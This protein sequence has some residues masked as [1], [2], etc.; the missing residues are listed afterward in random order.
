MTQNELRSYWF[1]RHGCFFN[2]RFRL[3]LTRHTWGKSLNT[4][5]H[6]TNPPIGIKAALLMNELLTV[7]EFHELLAAEAVSFRQL[8]HR[9][10]MK[11]GATNIPV[12]AT[13][14]E[15]IK[16]QEVLLYAFQH[17]LNSLEPASQYEIEQ[18]GLAEPR[19]KNS[20]DSIG[21]Q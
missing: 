17:G 9:H 13:P 11:D 8:I 2:R 3:A 4:P 21:D 20:T 10:I 18:L 6:K 7:P 15:L 12:S 19:L 14:T 1:R 5:M 16:A